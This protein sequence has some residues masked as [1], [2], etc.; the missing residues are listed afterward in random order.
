MAIPRKQIGWG[1]ESN[2][3]WGIWNAVDKLTRVTSKSK[4][5]SALP[6]RLISEASTNATLVKA[7]AGTLTTIT[8]I[9]LSEEAVSYL[10]IYDKASAPTVGTDVPVMTIPIPTNSLGA[11]VTISIPNGITFSNGIAI[12]VT[13]LVADSDTTAILADEVVI[14]LTYV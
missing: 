10:K 12:A 9:N 5:V 2:L 13:S 1:T 8:A 4:S 14:N 11:G 3:L 7:S 6:F